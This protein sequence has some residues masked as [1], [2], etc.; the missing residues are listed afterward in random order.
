VEKAK[1]FDVAK[2]RA[3]S[4]GITFN[5]PGG[6]VKIDGKTQHIHKTVRIGVVESNGQFKEV[7]N[8]G[9]PVKPDPYLDGYRGPKA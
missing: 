7:W 4:D 1:S 3:A 6:P 5:A 8:S 9:S 2:V